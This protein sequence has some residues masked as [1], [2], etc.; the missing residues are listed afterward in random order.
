VVARKK[1]QKPVKDSGE[2]T[3][4]AEPPPPPPPPSIHEASLAS[5]PSGAVEYGAV[6]DE[7]MAV[8]RRKAGEDVVVRGADEDANRVLAYRI[9]NAAGAASRP[10]FPHRR[11]AGPRAL[12]HFHQRSRSPKGHTFY[13]TENL[14]ASKKP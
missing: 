10:Q 3:P 11:S 6:I 7:G 4:P 12:P 8:A 14:K 9:E 5:G 2:A 1:K 13:E